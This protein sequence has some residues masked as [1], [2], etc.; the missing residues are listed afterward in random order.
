M[1]KAI[2]RESA[3]RESTDAYIN[4]LRSTTAPSYLQPKP[5]DPLEDAS[6]GRGLYGYIDLTPS[7]E[8]DQGI[9]VAV[10]THLNLVS[11]RFD[12]TE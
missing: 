7:E 3:I 9:S 1:E 10:S 8:H 2:I 12:A 5:S 6:L 11:L 4:R